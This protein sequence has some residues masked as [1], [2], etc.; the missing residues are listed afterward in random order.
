MLLN[1]YCVRSNS[2]TTEL[3]TETYEDGGGDLGN[4]WECAQALADL[5]GNLTAWRTSADTFRTIEWKNRIQAKIVEVT[6]LIRG[7]FDKSIYRT[8]SDKVEHEGKTYKLLHVLEYLRDNMKTMSEGSG[9][10]WGAAADV[11]SQFA[12]VQGLLNDLR[13]MKKSCDV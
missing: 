4:K 12:K 8:W 2:T 5:N 6:E 10:A 13:D 11:G 3:E 7:V 1:L 9:V